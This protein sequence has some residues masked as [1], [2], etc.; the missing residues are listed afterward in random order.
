MGL[1]RRRV[2]T[3][4]STAPALQVFRSDD[5]GRSWRYDPE[6][7][8]AL[9]QLIPEVD[10]PEVERLEWY[11]PETGIVFGR[12]G[13]R[14]LRTTDGGR[15]WQLLSV[16]V[17]SGIFQ[18]H[19]LTRVGSRTW[20]CGHSGNI[21]LSDD[22]GASWRT[23]AHSPFHA[24]DECAALSFLTPEDGWAVGTSATLWAT[25]DGGRTWR[26][27]PAPVQPP[28]TFLG[29]PAL[30]HLLGLVRLTPK[31]AW[32][33][34][35]SGLFK[36]M[37]GGQTWRLQPQAEP[38]ADAPFHVSRAPGGR[39]VLTWTPPG[40]PIEQ[41][42][43][44]FAW[45]WQASDHG[46]WS[47]RFPVPPRHQDLRLDV[48]G[49]RVLDGPLLTRGQGVMTLLEGVRQASPTQWFGWAGAQVVISENAGRRWFRGGGA[50]PRPIQELAPQRDG[51]LLAEVEGG[52]LWRLGE[53]GHTWTPAQGLL[54]AHDFELVAGRAPG[55]RAPVP[56]Q[57]RP[58]PES[59]FD[60]LLSQSQV[61]VDVWFGL[62]G[63]A[64]TRSELHLEHQPGGARLSGRL[65]PGID[66]P[67]VP[68]DTTLSREAE[69]RFLREWV[70]AATRPETR[71]QCRMSTEHEVQVEWSC[72]SGPLQRS[73]KAEFRS[74]G[75]T[76]Q[77]Q[78]HRALL[79]YGKD[80]A[81]SPA[82]YA[83]AV[84]LHEVARAALEA[85]APERPADVPGAHPGATR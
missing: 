5:A 45:A 72:G 48:K 35:S 73:W 56:G 71:K 64:E 68:V 46:V 53:E 27:L 63:F 67:E 30:S 66:K 38:P 47:A 10:Y 59:P 85:G 18:T 15:T 39:Q 7:S 9:S 84:G 61:R 75:C 29:L 49:V 4:E 12:L 13:P 14:L 33:W 26:A 76:P 28:Q 23:L 81:R 34:G 16:P 17:Q 22:Q 70:E 54:D 74:D 1:D 69:A 32:L 3:S 42:I 78:E 51:A 41:W 77:T 19:A 60:C 20:L 8:R 43:P 79:L 21:L 40:L 44:L 31:V 2:K 11:T 58:P 6:T 82:E 24:E 55:G 25:Q 36:S 62:H 57:P 83:R 52:Q 37:D 80:S 50:S 65:Q